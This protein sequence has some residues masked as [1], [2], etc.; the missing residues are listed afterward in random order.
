MRGIYCLGEQLVTSRKGLFSFELL[1]PT[2]YTPDLFFEQS[3]YLTEDATVHSAFMLFQLVAH[4]C[5]DRLFKHCTVCN[6]HVGVGEFAALQ[7]KT[8]FQSNMYDF[9]TL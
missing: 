4:A 6:T 1:K 2:L 9:H 8:L 7:Y 5:L 3:E